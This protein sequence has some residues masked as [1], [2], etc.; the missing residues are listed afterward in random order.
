V[1]KVENVTDMISVFY[2]DG[3]IHAR[4]FE[5]FKHKL[6]GIDLSFIESEKWNDIDL[7]E[8]DLSYTGI[9][10]NPQT[11]LNK[12]LRQTNLEG[13]DLSYLDAESFNEVDL[14][15][16]NLKGTGIKFNPQT[17]YNN[18]LN[19]TNLEDVDLINLPIE[20]WT[21]VNLAGANLKRT[22]IKFNP[23]LLT[24]KYLLGTDL[25]G[26][27]LSHI[28]EEEWNG[29]CLVRA[30]L[31]GTNIKFDPQLI[32][33]K[34]LVLAN[35]EDLDLSFIKEEDWTDID[36]SKA[37]LRGAKVNL[38]RNIKISSYTILPEEYNKWKLDDN[39]DFSFAYKWYE[40]ELALADYFDHLEYFTGKD[41]AFS[42]SKDQVD[43]LTKI[44]T[45]YLLK[46]ENT[47][48]RCDDAKIL[49]RTL[50]WYQV[51]EFIPNYELIKCIPIDKIK[52]FSMRKWHKLIS[53]F[54]KSE[55]GSNLITSMAKAAIV[56]GVFEDD[57]STSHVGFDKLMSLL[58]YIPPIIGADVKYSY[59]SEDFLRYYHENQISG[60]VL[61]NGVF[62]PSEFID[63]IDIFLDE[64][65]FQTIKNGHNHMLRTFVCNNYYPCSKYIYRLNDITNEED[66]AKIKLLVTEYNINYD[67]C[68]YAFHVL[69][70]NKMEAIFSDMKC[71]YYKDF[72]NMLI[73]NF[74][75]I[76]GNSQYAG[77]IANIQL[78]LKKII[79]KFGRNVDIIDCIRYLKEINY[80]G[81]NDGNCELAFFVKCVVYLKNVLINIKIFMNQLKSV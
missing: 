14:R 40:R 36:L 17:I 73:D 46:N 2:Y 70:C 47:L 31:K 9:R 11:I 44:K 66:A 59:L 18:Y 56:F 53:C 77:Q 51:K 52:N 64:K 4:W 29:V 22:G 5:R 72:Y 45:D 75:L 15:G 80:I 24:N 28:K 37:N 58:K 43:I 35:L 74:T 54:D 71:E 50:I 48:L 19:G 27:D 76:L 16:A 60:Y 38:P 57:V 81:V 25:E 41:L 8:L 7:S 1:I 61:H 12:R 26:V 49:D 65:A 79:S 30:N 42:F 13:V 3:T 6:K 34:S 32:E 63:Y 62:I 20:S 21:N 67:Y 10:F 55:R 68:D 69:D 23:Q 78:E 39:V 33:N